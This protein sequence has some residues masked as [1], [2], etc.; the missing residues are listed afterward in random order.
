MSLLILEDPGLYFEVEIKQSHLQDY[1][2]GVVSYL[3]REVMRLYFFF[4]C[5]FQIVTLI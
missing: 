2:F 3:N 1:D 5:D 4:F